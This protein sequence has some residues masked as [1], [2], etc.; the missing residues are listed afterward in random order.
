MLACFSVHRAHSQARAKSHARS[1]ALNNFILYCPI[2]K[3]GLALNAP[4]TDC[5]C[6]AGVST[7]RC[8]AG[9]AAVLAAAVFYSGKPLSTLTQTGLRS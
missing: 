8:P 5:K 1:P 3:E 6:K 9:D 2:A 4:Y 7:V